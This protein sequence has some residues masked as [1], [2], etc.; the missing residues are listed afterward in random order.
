M[1]IR[2]REFDNS[3]RILAQAIKV[4]SSSP[5]YHNL[6]RYLTEHQHACTTS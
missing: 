3:T 6:M 4:N 2:P 1:S 5:E